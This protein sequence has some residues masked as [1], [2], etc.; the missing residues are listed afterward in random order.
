VVGKIVGSDPKLRDEF[1]IYSAHL[2][3]MG[4]CTPAEAASGTCF[5]YPAEGNPDIVCHEALDNASGVAAVLEVARAFT[6]LPTAPRRSIL[7]LFTT[8][9]EDNFEGADYFVHS[10]TIPSMRMVADVNI[11]VLAGMRYPCKDF[12]VVGGEHSS[13]LHNA[14]FA[15]H[16]FGYEVNL[17]PFPLRNYFSRNDG[18]AFALQGIPAIFLRNGKDGDEVLAKWTASIYHTPLDSMDQPINWEAGLKAIKVNFLIGYDV[19]QQDDAPTWNKGNFFASLS[20]SRSSRQ[21]NT[22]T[23]TGRTAREH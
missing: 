9:E 7:F 6:N 1:V 19:A 4:A 16:R 15:V 14:E 11:D 20:D 21:K 12:I 2:D 22:R 13:L 18:Y 8:G 17:D 23:A 3:H 10:P 5:C